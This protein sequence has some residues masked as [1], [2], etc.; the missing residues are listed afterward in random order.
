MAIEVGLE[1]YE[2]VYMNIKQYLE[3][4]HIYYYFISFEI[5]FYNGNILKQ[6]IIRVLHSYSSYIIC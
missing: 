4:A 6:D 1:K 3:Y 2:E 5:P